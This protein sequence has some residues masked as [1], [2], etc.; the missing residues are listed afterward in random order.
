MS[1]TPLDPIIDCVYE[2]EPA[3]FDELTVLLRA[4]SLS[5]QKPAQKTSQVRPFRGYPSFE[6]NGKERDVINTVEMT[7]SD[8][9]NES[10]RAGMEGGASADRHGLRQVVMMPGGSIDP[11]Y[12]RMDGA[13]NPKYLLKDI[14]YA[15]EYSGGPPAERRDRDRRI[16][17]RRHL[18]GGARAW[19]DQLPSSTPDDWET[20]RNVFLERYGL[21]EIDEATRSFIVTRKVATLAQQPAES[22][23]A[24]L[25]RCEELLEQAGPTVANTFGLHAVEGLKDPDQRRLVQF[26]LKR[27]Q[28]YDYKS[29]RALILSAYS[30][31][32]AQ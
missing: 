9:P 19:F 5:S 2:Q 10:A 1:Y 27:E 22:V 6:Q 14:E 28:N 18:K 23:A 7:E 29:A 8:L 25:T 3:V 32:Q 12:G 26:T 31:I 15:I 20:L 13:E 30:D 11:F 16:L 21:T 4:L 17:F 24:Y